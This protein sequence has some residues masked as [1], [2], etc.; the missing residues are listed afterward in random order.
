MMTHMQ[1]RQK[2]LASDEAEE[3]RRELLAI[4]EDPNFNTASIYTSTESSESALFVEKH[5]TYMS[6]NLNITT[7]Q[8]LSNLKLRLRIR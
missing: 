1:S 6:N 2:F 4:A 5:M 3:F 8:Y 7:E